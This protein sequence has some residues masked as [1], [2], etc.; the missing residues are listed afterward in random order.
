MKVESLRFT[1]QMNSV[2]FI[3]DIKRVDITGK[4]NKFK[5]NY[6]ESHPIIAVLALPSTTTGCTGNR[7]PA[8]AYRQGRGVDGRL[9]VF[10]EVP[11][12]GVRLLH[13]GDREGDH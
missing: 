2:T 7:S 10:H 13:A 11:G 12:E 9:P 6:Y 1:F 5:H 3:N 4:D 8:G